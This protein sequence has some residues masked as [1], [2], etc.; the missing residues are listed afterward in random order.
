MLLLPRGREHHQH[1]PTATEE[2]A[3]VKP[4]NWLSLAFLAGIGFMCFRPMQTY[5][6]LW[7]IPLYTDVYGLSRIAASSIVMLMPLGNVVGNL[8]MA[9]I[10]ARARIP[11]KQMMTLNVF[12]SLLC[13][14]PIT[15]AT[16]SMALGV[17]YLVSLILDLATSLTSVT[18]NSISPLWL[19]DKNQTATLALINTGN[20]ADAAVFQLGI[21][22]I[23][24][25]TAARSVDAQ[26]QAT[27]LLAFARMTVAFVF[28]LLKTRLLRKKM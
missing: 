25:A 3:P 9:V 23:I 10:M 21:N 15:F 24:D 12:V 28:A 27:Y 20:I 5:Q 7:G 4:T 1:T 26:Y 19:G 6:G 2:A 11:K 13:Y 18:I 14:I 22:R 17:T 8:V 16:S